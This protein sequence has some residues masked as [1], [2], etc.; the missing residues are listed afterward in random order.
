MSVLLSY[1]FFILYKLL[2]FAKPQEQEDDE[3][4]LCRYLHVER[5]IFEIKIIKFYYGTIT[6]G[7]VVIIIS[8]YKINYHIFSVYDNEIKSKKKYIRK[9]M[10]NSILKICFSFIFCSH[11]SRLLPKHS[12]NNSIPIFFWKRKKS[13]RNG[14]KINNIVMRFIL[15]FL[16]KYVAYYVLC[17]CYVTGM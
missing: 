1:F 7:K 10:K 15:W 5:N 14:K 11:V 13:I 3:K 16:Y 17:V 2:P 12:P 9:S 4:N 6:K 8:W